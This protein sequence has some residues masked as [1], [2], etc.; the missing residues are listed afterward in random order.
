VN[1][2]PIPFNRPSIGRSEYEYIKKS[3]DGKLCG[4]GSFTK[5]AT[6]LFEK[7]TKAAGMLLT[8]SCTHALELAA[9][10][11]GISSGDEVILPSYTFSSTANAFLL[12][13]AKLV[14]CDI[15]TKTMNMDENLLPSLITN[16]T[17]AIVPVHYAGVACEM[18]AINEIAKKYGLFVVEDAAQAVGSYYKDKPCGALSDIGCY[19]FHE[20]KNYCMGEGGGII[21]SDR[22]MRERAE[23][24]REKGTDRISFLRGE[25]DKYTWRE[26][27][28]SYLPSDILAGLLCAQ[29]TRFDE[30]MKKRLR[31]WNAYH[32]AFEPLE[33]KEWQR[34][35]IPE[36]CKHNAHMYYLLSPSPGE[37]TGLIEWLKKRGIT[38]VSHYEPLHASPMGISLGYGI[39]DLP[40]TLDYASRLIRLPIWPEM[41]DES[42][43][44]VIE[45]VLTGVARNI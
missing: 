26:I 24:I 31:I 28:S 45:N 41:D 40:L 9:L 36:K 7:A 44:R 10:L 32:A 12:R 6:I 4:D 15:K 20:T 11:C 30:I 3:L 39:K 14:F 13:G 19:S 37:R 38:A 17:K 29:L 34:P 8:T 23:M 1:S 33:K 21:I 42:L 18:D 43:Q 5:E 22:K 35:F 16:K 27:G 2:L 25:V